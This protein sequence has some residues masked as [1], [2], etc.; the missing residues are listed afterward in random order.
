MHVLETK[1]GAT[2]KDKGD[3]IGWEDDEETVGPIALAA[4]KSLLKAVPHILLRE[5]AEVIYKLVIEHGDFGIHN[6]SINKDDNERPLVTS[7]MIGR[8]HALYQ[9]F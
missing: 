9:H 7:Y 4:K 2:I 8:R 1:I 6:T 3:I 5:N